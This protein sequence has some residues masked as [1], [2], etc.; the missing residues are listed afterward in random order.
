MKRHFFSIACLLLLGI[1]TAC[2]G[3]S[4]APAE[5]VREAEASGEEPQSVAEAMKK[6]EE[7]VGQMNE[8]KAA[9][10]MDFRELK[11]LL[12][13]RLIGLERT[14]HSG[15]KAGAMGFVVSNA[16]A[17]Y[18]DGDR[19]LE[20][21]IV[22]T[23]GIMGAAMGLASWATVEV[24][25]E[26]Q[27]GYERTTVIDGHKAF[28]SYNTTDRSGELNLLIGD[29]IVVTLN[30]RNLEAGELRTA[31]EQIDLGELGN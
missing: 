1:L 14:T 25:R 5:N 27:D 12:P 4:E 17:E 20:V 28:E 21:K 2:G 3:G 24:D 11:A 29:R 22:D 8:G 15:E 6:V 30:G 26:T 31:L 18:E 9:E 19:R 13:E 23:G 10:V 7:A 16:E